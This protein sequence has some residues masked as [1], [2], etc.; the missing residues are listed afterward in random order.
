M[1][2]SEKLK[3]LLENEII[4]DLEQEID[5]MFQM[6]E[7]EKTISIADREE[8]DEMQEMHRECKDILEEISLGEMDEN[9]A[10]ELLA[11]LIELKSE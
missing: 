3:N 1:K 5:A 8:L 6:V 9:E 7:R 4:Q 11:E 10:T 2:S